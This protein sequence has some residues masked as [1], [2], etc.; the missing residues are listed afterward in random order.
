[1]RCVLWTLVFMAGAMLLACSGTTTPQSPEE[2]EAVGQQRVSEATDGT[3]WDA[4]A[5]AERLVR[6]QLQHPDDAEFIMALERDCTRTAP[7]KGQRHW[8]VTGKV[9][10]ANGF[11]AKLT[12]PYGIQLYKSGS[13]WQAEMV[14]LDGEIVFYEPAS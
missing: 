10:A 11:G 14:K 9:K 4:C 13:T 5:A 12:I 3:W 1:M 2:K 8:I 6:A 7:V